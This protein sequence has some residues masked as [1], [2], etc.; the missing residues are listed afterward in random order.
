LSVSCAS[1]GN[2]AVGGDYTDGQLG[3]DL[4]SLTDAMNDPGAERSL[5]KRDRRRALDPQLRL[6]ARH[7]KSCYRPPRRTWP[8]PSPQHEQQPRSSDNYSLRPA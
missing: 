5:I 2:C 7:G 6:N 8:S 1:A 3:D 4:I